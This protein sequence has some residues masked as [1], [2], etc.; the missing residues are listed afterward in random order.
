MVSVH[1]FLIKITRQ[2]SYSASSS[3]AHGHPLNL[4]VFKKKK[5][6]ALHDIVSITCVIYQKS[7]YM[8]YILS[9]M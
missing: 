2:A 5:K 9:H 7:S 6:L 4:H 3:H 1:M 8:Y